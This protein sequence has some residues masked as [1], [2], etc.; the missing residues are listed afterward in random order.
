M[1][2]VNGNAAKEESMFSQHEKRIFITEFRYS[3][4]LVY[5]LLL[6]FKTCVSSVIENCEDLMNLVSKD[7]QPDEYNKLEDGIKDA[8]ELLEEVFGNMPSKNAQCMHGLR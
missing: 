4:E 1:Y 2:C 7:K 3:P 5:Q 6:S 8:K